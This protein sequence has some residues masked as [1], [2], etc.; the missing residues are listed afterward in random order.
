[1]RRGCGSPATLLVADDAET[2][3]GGFSAPQ[4]RFATLPCQAAIVHVLETAGG[5]VRVEPAGRPS[6]FPLL[7]PDEAAWVAET[8]AD[9]I[10][11]VPGPGTDVLG[12]LVVG[13]RLDGRMVRSVD[14]PFLEALGAAA[15]L[16][17]TR[18]ARGRGR[19]RRP[20]SARSADR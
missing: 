8:G 19:R 14:L 5:P 2:H 1:M 13:R 15:G 4:A 17:L 18:R 7:P 9:V 12:V 6:V 11:P 20:R 10:V 16:A 3:A